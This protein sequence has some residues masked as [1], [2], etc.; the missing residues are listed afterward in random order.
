MI[1]IPIYALHRH[2]KYWDRPNVFDP[3]RFIHGRF[4]GREHRYSY[5]PFGAGSRIYLGMAFARA[6]AQPVL[7]TLLQ[8]L[9]FETA[10]DRPIEFESAVL[11]LGKASR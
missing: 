6:K 1:L 9:T 4:N 10:D 3:D 8:S 11:R 2:K 5:M 7:A